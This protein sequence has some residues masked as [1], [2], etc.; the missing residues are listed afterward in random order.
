MNVNQPIT[1]PAI[2][3]GIGERT[4]QMTIHQ[5]CAAIGINVTADEAIEVAARLVEAAAKL[6][7]EKSAP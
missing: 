6:D 2:G 5:P 7:Q 3:I 4:V 1:V